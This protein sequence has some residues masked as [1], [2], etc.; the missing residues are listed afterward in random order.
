M[1]EEKSFKPTKRKLDRARKEGRVLKSQL[2]TQFAVL[3]AGFCLIKSF[4]G[5]IW[6]APRMLLEYG[7]SNPDIALSQVLGAVKGMVIQ[8]VT[9][10]VGSFALAGVAA[11]V[12]QVGFTI[13][14]AVLAPKLDRLN[15]VSGLKRIAGSLARAWEPLVRVLAVF[16]VGIV[17]LEG[18]LFGL[19]QVTWSQ[20]A[21]V[22]PQGLQGLLAVAKWLLCVVAL[23]AGFDYFRRYREFYRELSM[24]HQEMREEH[25]ELEGQPLVKALRRAMHESLAMQ[26]IE[27]R[28]RSSKVIVVRRAAAR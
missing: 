13:E 22:V 6:V 16:L 1:A 19:A 20:A 12:A 23:G 27:R 5:E 18:V 26:D 15:P 7:L 24:D 17:A 8:M 25:K 21:V 9:I 3:G 11:E 14:P 28:V 10:G 2:V 4:G